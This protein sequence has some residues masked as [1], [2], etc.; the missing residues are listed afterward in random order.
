MEYR[1]ESL[2]HIALIKLYWL[3]GRK[4]IRLTY[5][6]V[7][8]PLS[9]TVSASLS[10]NFVFLAFSS[11]A[12]PQDNSAVTGAVG[13]KRLHEDIHTVGSVFFLVT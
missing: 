9:R 2:S 13:S 5:L 6:L 3:A 10:I 12:V 8:Q 7:T 11:L 4:S 1:V